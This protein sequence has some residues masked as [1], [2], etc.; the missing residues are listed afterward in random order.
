MCN[1]ETL[2]VAS[3]LISV[4]IDETIPS[5]IIPRIQYNDTIESL[6]YDQGCWTAKLKNVRAGLIKFYIII[7]QF[8]KEFQISLNSGFEEDDLF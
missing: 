3:P 7:D 1:K 8:K 4:L 5:D 6:K 2:D